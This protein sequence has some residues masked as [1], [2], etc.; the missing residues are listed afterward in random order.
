VK[1]VF[2]VKQGNGLDQWFRTI[3]PVINPISMM[4]II[5]VPIQSCTRGRGG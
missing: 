1:H 2:I 5:A 4:L 3:D